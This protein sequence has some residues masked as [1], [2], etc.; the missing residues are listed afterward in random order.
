[1]FCGG[2][3][4]GGEARMGGFAAKFRGFRVVRGCGA[5]IQRTADSTGV[6]GA[7]NF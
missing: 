6:V 3:R 5:A 2:F 7:K 1:M 4:G